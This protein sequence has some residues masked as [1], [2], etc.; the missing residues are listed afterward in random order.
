MPAGPEDRARR[1]AIRRI[2]RR[3]RRRHLGQD[4]VSRLRPGHQLGRYDETLRV[5]AFGKCCWPL[6]GRRRSGQVTRPALLLSGPRHS[7]PTGRARVT[8]DIFWLLSGMATAPV[9]R[10]LAPMARDRPPGLLPAVQPPGPDGHRELDC[11]RRR[12]QARVGRNEE[13]MSGSIDSQTVKVSE[14]GGSRGDHGGE[15]IYSRKRHVVMDDEAKLLS[16]QVHSAV[17][18]GR[19][20]AVALLRQVHEAH[21]EVAK[22]QADGGCA[23]GKLRAPLSQVAPRFAVE[24]VMMG[25]LGGCELLPGRRVMVRILAWQTHVEAA[26]QELRADGR[27]GGRTPRP[28]RGK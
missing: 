16:A 28:R 11:L 25:S 4:T 6:A 5:R 21:S 18:R 13:V 23:G 3:G 22:I 2:V 12:E 8:T 9:C 19:D 26:C 14:C 27:D 10:E 7:R 15:K 24:I 17:I 1:S 20:G